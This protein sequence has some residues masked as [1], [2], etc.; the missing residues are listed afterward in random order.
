MAPFLLVTSLRVTKYSHSNNRIIVC[1]CMYIH[2]I[3]IY[4]A[5]N[6]SLVCNNTDLRLVG[7]TAPHEGNIEVCFN[8]Q[9]GSICHDN[10]GIADAQTVC[11]ILGFGNGY[12][13]C[14]NYCTCP[15]GT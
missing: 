8:G 1:N 13:Q 9:W 5:D 11:R 10:W 15:L 12:G 2:I 14:Y 6:A 4:T 3:L 7:S